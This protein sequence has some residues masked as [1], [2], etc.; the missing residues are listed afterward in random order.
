MTP[1]ALAEAALPVCD[2]PP[3]PPR[4]IPWAKPTLVGRERDYVL[5]ALESSWIS[6]GPF[7][8]RLEK[9]VPARMGVGH[10]VA[11]A[12]GTAALHLALLGLGIGPGDEVIVPAFTFIAAAN[13]TLMVGATL[14]AADIDPEG[15]CLDPD[16]V[17]KRITQR[18]KAIIPVHLYGNIAAM[19]PLLRLGEAHGIPIIEDAAEAAFS[20]YQGRAAGT[21]GRIGTFSFHATKTI[22]TGEGGM[23]VTD[24]GALAERLRKIRDHGMRKDRRYWHDIVA[25]NF[26]M[27]NLVAAIGCAQLEKLDAIIAERARVQAAY[28]RHLAGI[29][30]VRAQ[31]FAPEVKPVLWALAVQLLAPEAA[32]RR[33]AVMDT[34]E[35][36]GIET[37]PGF[38]D[39]AQLPP[40]GCPALPVAAKVSR[41]VLSLPTYP[42]LSDADIAFICRVFAHAI[43]RHGLGH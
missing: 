34:L 41:T 19:E 22:T 1:T 38:Y 42:D 4:R 21:M 23:V 11:V 16:D 39:L 33:Q 37:R 28:R 3:P 5:E 15:W 30:G 10:G 32:E 13:M 17:A 14:V 24:D 8:D 36:E 12:N 35:Q 9:E 40:Y 31:L 2:A 7:V 20:T 25:H 26:R 6:G 18:T 27:P 43:R 29:D